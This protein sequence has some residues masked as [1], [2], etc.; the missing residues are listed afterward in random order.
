MEFRT[1]ALSVGLQWI[2]LS[3]DNTA[4]GQHPPIT[5]LHRLMQTGQCLRNLAN[6]MKIKNQKHR[7]L[8][9]KSGCLVYRPGAGVRNIDLKLLVMHS[10]TVIDSYGLKQIITN[11]IYVSY[12]KNISLDK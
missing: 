2:T 7:N 1:S 3:A 5:V 9:D 11:F 6:V 10:K 8:K 4:Y 12:V